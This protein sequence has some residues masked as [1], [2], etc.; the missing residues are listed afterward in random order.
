MPGSR[1]LP[2]DVAMSSFGQSQTSTTQVPVM[3]VGLKN[4]TVT[5]QGPYNAQ[6]AAA[7]TTDVVQVG[8]DYAVW[9]YTQ[10]IPLDANSTNLKDP[11]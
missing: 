1:P 8:A 3:F 7:A 4:K 5:D 10:N 2:T 9:D 11:V 6:Q